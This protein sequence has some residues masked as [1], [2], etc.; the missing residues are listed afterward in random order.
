MRGKF[1][2]GVAPYFYVFLPC[3]LMLFVIFIPMIDTLRLSLVN[4]SYIKP[5]LDAAFVGFDN[6]KKVFS[7]NLFWK[8]LWTTIIWT[9]TSVIFQ[10]LLGFYM[11]LLIRAREGILNKVA[12]SLFLIPWMLPGALASI[13]WKWIFNGTTGLVNFLLLGMHII[14]KPQMWL[15]DTKLVLWSAIAVNIWR[16]APFFMIMLTGGLK[17]ISKDIYEAATIDGAN[18]VQKFFYLT[19]TEL[20]PLI[21]TVLIYNTIGA[22]NYIDIIIALTGGGPANHTMILSLYAWNQAFS[23]NRVS[24]AATISILSC[25]TLAILSLIVFLTNSII[26]GFVKRENCSSGNSDFGG[27]DY[28]T[29]E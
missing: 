17:T 12:R 7:D 13:M 11:A 29:I 16:G 8:S 1:S 10:F 25:L 22:Y 26:R 18:A 23:N 21:I 4:A 15:S 24:L 14:S 27:V 3:L 19:L 9:I 6:Y 5:G 20:K 2:M 28:E